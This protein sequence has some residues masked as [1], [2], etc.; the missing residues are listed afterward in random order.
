MCVRFNINVCVCV[1]VFY[2][3]TSDLL[4]LANWYKK[5]FVFEKMLQN[6]TCCHR[7][8]LETMTFNPYMCT[9]EQQRPL[10]CN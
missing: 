3:N 8:A 5:V 2:E 4:S 9:V 7:K 10:K 1:C 6:L